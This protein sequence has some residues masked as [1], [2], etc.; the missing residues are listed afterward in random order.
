MYEK[1]SIHPRNVMHRLE[2]FQQIKKIS[3]EDKKD[4]KAFLDDLAIGRV[5]KGKRISDARRLKYLDMLRIPFIFFNKPIS[6]LTLGDMK[7]F[8][9]ALLV[10]IIKKADGKNPL[11]E[12]TKITIKCML[13]AY[14]NWKLPK[15]KAF[16]LV[17]WIDTRLP[18]KKTVP[19]LKEEE[20]ERLIKG[21]KTNKERFTVTILFDAGTR[22]EEFLNIR[23]EDIQETNEYNPYY[24][25]TLKEEY[26]KTNGRTI[27][28]YWKKS[29][30]IVSDYLKERKL[31]GARSQDP[32]VDW[33]Y[34]ALRMFLNRLG[35]RILK[36]S[37]HPH[38]FRHSSATYFASRLNRQELC[39]RFGWKFSSDMPDI[40]I[41]RAGMA[42]SKVD[43]KLLNYSL[44]EQARVISKLKEEN[45]IFSEMLQNVKMQ[46]ENIAKK[47]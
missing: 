31:E 7:R 40:Y 25:L 3:S 43:E 38:L 34:P 16:D 17:S 45:R 46:L 9:N 23:F 22:A 6:S 41:S 30:E 15:K 26:S 14:I 13:K 35:K 29:S 21:C 24:K 33:S 27:S 5:N 19:Y 47:K 10:D 2:T 42:E 44:D 4:M 32:L 18:K 37:I 39:Y 36:K 12:E 28:L 1:I 20:I 8:E 11:S